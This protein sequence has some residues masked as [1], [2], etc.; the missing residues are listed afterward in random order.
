MCEFGGF[1]PLEVLT[2]ATKNSAKFVQREDELG[3]IE[4]GKIADI[5]VVKGNP[6]EDI[7]LMVGP[8]Q[9]KVVIQGGEIM[10]KVLE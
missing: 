6:A 4:P 7:N 2:I 5:I 1:T 3:T 8:D 9:I 10:K